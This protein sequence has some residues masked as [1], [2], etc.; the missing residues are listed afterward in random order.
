M[1]SKPFATSKTS[2]TTKHSIDEAALIAAACARYDR[3]VAPVKKHSLLDWLLGEEAE[4]L[5]DQGNKAYQT[6]PR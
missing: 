2:S 1:N 5:K 6:N 3:L 4:A